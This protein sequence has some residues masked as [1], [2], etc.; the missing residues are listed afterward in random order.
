MAFY[1]PYSA[2]IGNGYMMGMSGY[3]GMAVRGVKCS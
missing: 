3:P 2:M 1:D